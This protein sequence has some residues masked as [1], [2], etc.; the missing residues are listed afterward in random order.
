MGIQMSLS[1]MGHVSAYRIILKSSDPAATT[2]AIGQVQEE[3]RELAIQTRG[4][5]VRHR[6]E[7]YRNTTGRDKMEGEKASDRTRLALFLQK[8]TTEAQTDSPVLTEMSTL[9][10]LQG[11]ETPTN[12]L[13]GRSEV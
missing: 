4:S 7:S 10:V 2:T 1:M 3:E 6:F 9:M 5:L 13:K 12:T 11:I 8:R